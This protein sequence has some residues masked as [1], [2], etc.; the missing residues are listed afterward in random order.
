[1]AHR[2]RRKVGDV[3]TIPNLITVARLCC[4]PLIVYAMMVD[5]MVVAFLLF[6][7]AGVSDGIDGFIA[8]HYDQHS[9]LGE[10]IDPVADKLLLVSV[11]VMLGFLGAVPIWLVIAAVARDFLIVAAVLLSSLMTHPVAMRPI[12]LSKANTAF[13]IALVVVV[14][15]ELAFDVPLGGLGGILVIVVA[16]LTVLSGAAYLK[17][18]LQHMADAH[19][20]DRQGER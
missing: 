12:F 15:A 16:V 18:W 14:M 3:M 11:F 2:V 10:Y 9:R 20:G 13:Q 8:R 7:A 6:V 4:V 5:E 1:M 17:D 19:E